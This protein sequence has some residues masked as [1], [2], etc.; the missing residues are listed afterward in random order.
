MW[1][2]TMEDGMANFLRAWEKSLDHSMKGVADS[3]SAG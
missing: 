1:D 2:G 3:Q